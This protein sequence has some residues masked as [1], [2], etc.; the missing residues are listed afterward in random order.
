MRATTA[1][2][3]M[4][5]IPGAHVAG[6][7]FT[8]DGIVVA[9]RRRSARLRCT[10]GWSTRSVYDRSTRRSRDAAGGGVARSLHTPQRSQTKTVGVDQ[11]GVASSLDP[12][13]QFT[14]ASSCL[15]SG[16][17]ARRSRTR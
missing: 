5:Q 7:E 1:F 17:L 13:Q 16:D 4:L 15:D 11:H 2:N 12:A 10:C 8:A 9:V 14:H 3:K 6:V